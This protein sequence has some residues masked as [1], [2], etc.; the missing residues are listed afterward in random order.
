L[1]YLDALSR[2]L[3]QKQ[4]IEHAVV[5]WQPEAGNAGLQDDRQKLLLAMHYGKM[6]SWDQLKG[7]GRSKKG[8][9]FQ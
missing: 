8:E 3:G 4:G 9:G 5:D 1:P 2:P 7:K 6:V